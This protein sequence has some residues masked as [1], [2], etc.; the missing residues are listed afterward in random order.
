M[1]YNRCIL[2]GRLVAN[3]ET[4]TGKTAFVTFM[5]AINAREQEVNFLPCVAFGKTGEM[6]AKYFEKGKEI[7][8]EGR[9]TSRK[10][11]DKTY[12]SVVAERFEFCGYQ[13]KKPQ[14]SSD[15]VDKAMTRHARSLNK[16][17]PPNVQDDIPF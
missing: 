9:L 16:D 12:Y 1:N 11:K 15:D 2:G 6:I 7:L 17:N 13:D 4:K 3:P 10:S 8:I 5:L 14:I